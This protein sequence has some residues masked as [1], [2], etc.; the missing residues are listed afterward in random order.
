MIAH[1]IWEPARKET[2]VHEACQPLRSLLCTTPGSARGERRIPQH[3]PHN[4]A[5]N[6]W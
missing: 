4:L 1:T 3:V 5:R 2:E 6:V